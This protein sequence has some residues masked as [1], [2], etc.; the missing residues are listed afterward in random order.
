MNYLKHKYQQMTGD[1]KDNFES[2]NFSTCIVA[3]NDDEDEL[4][5]N[6]K[7][8]RAIANHFHNVISLVGP[9]GVGKSTLSS[10]I[11]NVMRND[12]N[13]YFA[14]SDCLEG[15]TKG[16][17][18][19]KESIKVSKANC[20]SINVLDLEGLE[21]EDIIHYLVV[22]AMALSKALLL[23]ARYD[24]T[25]RFKFDVF[26]TLISGIRVYQDNGIAVPQPVIYVQVPFGMKTFKLRKSEVDGNGLIAHIKK[27]FK[28]LA[29][30]EMRLF[31]LPEFKNDTRFDNEYL[32]AV[33]VLI[34]ELNGINEG[35][36]IEERVQ[37][38]TVVTV[39][40]NKHSPVMIADMNLKF[41]K[42]AIERKSAAIQTNAIVTLRENSDSQR[43]E[44]NMS[45][46]DFCNLVCLNG[47]YRFGETIKKQ[48]IASSYFDK[49]NAHH[50]KII[51]DFDDEKKYYIQPKDHCKDIY[52]KLIANLK[53]RLAAKGEQIM[54]IN[55]EAFESYI[56]AE[57]KQA[58]NKIKYDGYTGMPNQL[59]S[60]VKEKQR[61]F[62]IETIEKTQNMV[63]LPDDYLDMNMLD[64]SWETAVNSLKQEWMDKKK[65]ALSD[66]RKV[67]TSGDTTCPSC[68]KKHG[69]GVSNLKESCYKSNS[70]YYW[71]DGP[72]N[73]CVC[74]ICEETSVIT[75][76]CCASSNCGATLSNCSIIRI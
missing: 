61:Q 38:A 7:A 27:K 11:Y 76:V 50:R 36:P 69:D 51:D 4:R 47:V 60:M 43:L 16:I 39:A 75:S 53:S 25:P 59:R 68:G 12:K 21:D 34:N 9:P 54:K 42:N 19:L 37:Y 46:N 56:G 30:F 62:K 5:L 71:V 63:N 73:T 52:N 32:K 44:K 40:L 13:E 14:A 28:D 66:R 1:S 23:C 22:V 57:V 31:S 33:K 48:A 2:D 65:R 64:R 3:P 74:D 6:T 29:G 17:W 67:L 72:T 10:T 49:E 20:D 8:F 26:K 35:V 70:I 41:F 24:G 45:F 55:S 58:S 15:F 18:T